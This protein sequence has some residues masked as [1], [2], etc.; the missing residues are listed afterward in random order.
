MGPGYWN[1]I[2]NSPDTYEELLDCFYEIS[3]ARK[4][5]LLDL[6]KIASS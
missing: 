5:A 6:L 4:D 1:F 2:D 3:L